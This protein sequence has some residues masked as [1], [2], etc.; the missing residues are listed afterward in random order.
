[1]KQFNGSRNNAVCCLAVAGLTASVVSLPAVADVWVFEPSISLDQRFDDNYYLIS[2]GDGSLTATRVVGELG[3][4]RESEAV[5]YR[6]LVRIDGLLTTTND[7]GDEGLDSNQ[8]LAFDAN[9]RSARSRTGMLAS[10]KQDTP[11]RDIAADLSDSDNLAS[12]TGLDLTQ[13]SNVARQEFIL[14]PTFEYDLSRRLILDSKLTLSRV[15]HALPDAQD[16]IYQRYIALYENGF[17]GDAPL[18]PYD[19][20]TIDDIGVFTVSGELDD[21]TESEVGLGLRFKYSTITTLSATASYSHFKAEVEPNAFAYIDAADKTPDPD[22]KDILRSPSRDSISTTATFKLG[23]ERSL[24]PTMKLAVDGGV[25]TNTTDESDTLRDGDR[26]PGVEITQEFLDIQ[27]SLESDSDGWLA[28]ISLSYD[29][30]LTRYVARYA[31][32]VE[33]SSSGSQVETNELTGD[34]YRI[35][36]PRLNFSLRARAFEPDRLGVNQNDSYARRFISIE[37][38]IEWKAARNWTV[39][40]AYRYRRQ[41]ARI[42]PVSAESNAILLSLKYT[43][44]SEARDAARANGL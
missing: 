6:G 15:E 26:A 7:N 16:T 36:S 30:G 17:F 21:Y 44:P 4:S 34:L 12:D 20:V 32:D 3:L 14:E 23:F 25:Y 11:S 1:M 41:K 37:P 24:T 8:Y 39:S 42:T 28:S 33:P 29:A 9:W 2:D 27:N 13:S 40:A 18:Q 35:L 38:K 43:V 22:E 31:V 5:S 19:E 10:Y